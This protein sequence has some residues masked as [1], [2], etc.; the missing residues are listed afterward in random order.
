VKRASGR[1]LTQ[2]PLVVLVNEGSASASEILSGAIQDNNRGVVVGKKTFGKGLIQSV[3]GLSDGSGMTVTIAKY[4]TPS[5]KDIHKQG[6]TPDVNA[7][8]SKA[9]AQRLKFEDLGTRND[10]QYRVAESELA[11]LLRQNNAKPEVSF[12]GE[13]QLDVFSTN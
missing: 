6:I 11:K 3:R 5:G 4:L 13:V 10:S 8:L 2:A 7:N 9:Q 12:D 1:A